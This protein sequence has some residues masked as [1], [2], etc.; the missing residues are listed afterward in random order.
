LTVPGHKRN[1][2]DGLVAALAAG[3]SNV[4]AAAR[5]GVNERTVRRRLEDPAFRGRVDEAR[6]DLVRQAVGKL[7]EV[8]ALAGETLAALV[9]EGESGTVKL[10][11]CR[12][13]LEYMFRGIEVDA[14]ARQ[15]AELRRELEGLKR[16]DGGHQG[17]VEP[18][19]EAGSRPPGGDADPPAGGLE[20][21]P[22]PPDD[23]GGAEPGPLAG[24]PAPSFR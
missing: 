19:E 23:A 1:L 3:A 18:A 15:V 24:R 11:A 10:G 4:A 2:D 16:G 14:L 6:A 9:R 17:G 7:A 22:R 20:G 5:A 8:G 21:G 12:A 13:V